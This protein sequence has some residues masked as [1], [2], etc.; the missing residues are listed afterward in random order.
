MQIEEALNDYM[1]YIQAVDQKAAATI[2]SYHSDLLEYQA[3]L[4]AQGIVHMEDISYSN[5]QDFLEYLRLDHVD[6]DGNIIA[7]ARKTSSINHMISSL[8]TFHRYITM[9]YPTIYDPAY[10]IRSKKSAKHLP[11]YFN[12]HDIEILL[13]SFGT[14]DQELF[15][16]AILELLYGCGLR[17][18]ECCSLTL[19]QLHLE[20]GFLRVIG[21]GDKERMIPM[22]ERCIKAIRVYL[23][24]DRRHWEKKRSPYVFI[25]A[26]GN[27]CTRQYV[28]TL[29]KQKL[30]ECG[31][32]EQ[33][34]AHSFRHSFATHLLDGGADLRVVQ[35]LLGHSD[36]T[37]TQIYT[38]VQS[39]RLKNV[40]TSS[41]PRAKLNKKESK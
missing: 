28:H 32:N 31:L 15:E 4:A 38:H 34:S 8:H 10:H 12:V 19:N 7:H 30:K 11:A 14:S 6:E 37:T 2:A 13:D 39:N 25:N 3:Y 1:N 18:S 20:Q 23:D 35:E 22:H 29:I 5:L 21:K 36:I 17:V 40:Y 26:S 27:R 16:K 24:I 41:H 33:L 9:T